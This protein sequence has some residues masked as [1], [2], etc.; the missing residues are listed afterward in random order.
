MPHRPALTRSLSLFA[1]AGLA[2]IAVLATSVAPSPAAAADNTCRRKPGSN[3]PQPYF[4]QFPTGKSA[5]TAAQ[6][7][8]AADLAKRSNDTFAQ[9]ICIFGSADKTGSVAANEKLSKAR[10]QAV[11]NAI[12]AAGTK[13]ELVIV[14][15]GEPVPSVGGVLNQ[16]AQADR[17]VQVIFS[18]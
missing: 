10:A 7:K 13:A 16:Q 5:L 17:S 14:G 3:F 11:A 8:E 15:Q 6:K 1:L 4:F 12:K 9:Q 18:N 2:T